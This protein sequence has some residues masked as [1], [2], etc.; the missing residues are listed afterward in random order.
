[1]IE[2]NTK[3]HVLKYTIYM[4][5]QYDDCVDSRNTYK[6]NLLNSKASL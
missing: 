6:P 3:I 5:R 4:Q 2:V 1:M